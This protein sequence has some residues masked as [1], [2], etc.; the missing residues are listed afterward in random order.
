M[1]VLDEIMA[2]KVLEVAERRR[3]V[4]DAELE[5]RAREAAPPRDLFAALSPR[6]GPMR[7]IAEVKR[8]S[9]SAGA[10]SAGR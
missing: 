9:P 8:A 1:S 10:I 3:A 7:V 6:G 4:P 5:A 2:R